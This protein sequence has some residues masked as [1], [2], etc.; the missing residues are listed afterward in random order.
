MGIRSSEGRT[1]AVTAFAAVPASSCP[2]V[3]FF[4]FEEP[5][6]VGE[7][8]SF[9]ELLLEEAVD[10]ALLDVFA[11]L[12]AFDDCFELELE[13]ELE[14][15]D[16]PDAEPDDGDNAVAFDVRP[17]TEP[18]LALPEAG[19]ASDTAFDVRPDVVLCDPLLRAEP[20]PLELLDDDCFAPDPE[21]P[22]PPLPPS[23]PEPLPDLS[24]ELLDFSSL[25][26]FLSEPLLLSEFSGAGA[27]G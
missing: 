1:I 21:G 25:T 20:F 13:L 2:P 14:L 16:D 8:L 12:L 17:D 22:L 5:V 7:A 6:C 23:L 11:V 27:S 3:E 15:E 26:F 19:A 9:L 24:S 18:V 10:L 4:A